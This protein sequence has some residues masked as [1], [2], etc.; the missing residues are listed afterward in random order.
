[1]IVAYSFLAFAKYFLTG[2]LMLLIFMRLYT[3][4]TPY[5]EWDLIQ[6]GRVTA[7]V[8]F[9]GAM[10][11]FVIAIVAA[12]RASVSI[13][14]FLIWGVVAGIVQCVVFWTCFK[15]FPSVKDQENLAAGIFFAFCSVS[16]GLLNGAS[17]IP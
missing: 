16:C 4:V 6:K 2:S 10:T 7:A 9:G 13:P 15:A 14:E 1:M 17:M 12:S 11:G 8:T 5:N 3:W